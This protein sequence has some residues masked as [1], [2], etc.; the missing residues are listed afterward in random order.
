[1]S[2]TSQIGTPDIQMPNL[3]S[4]SNQGLTSSKLGTRSFSLNLIA[5]RLGRKDSKRVQ[6][7]DLSTNSDREE[8]LL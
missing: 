1:M 2:R 4:R 5:R 3:D 7:I 8:K 6:R